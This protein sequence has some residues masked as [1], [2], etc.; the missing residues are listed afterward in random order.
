MNTCPAMMIK[1]MNFFLN[2]KES[3]GET[4]RENP[5]TIPS[6]NKNHSGEKLNEG[7]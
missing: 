4:K 5:R 7:G 2:G 6:E 1:K 3:S